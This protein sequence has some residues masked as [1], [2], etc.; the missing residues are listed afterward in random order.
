M[1]KI[2]QDYLELF[3]AF[4]VYKSQ[5]GYNNKLT[6]KQ[7]MSAYRKLVIKVNDIESFSKD[8][9]IPLEHRDILHY[10]SSDPVKSINNN[11]S[12]ISI[13]SIIQKDNLVNI[14]LL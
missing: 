13:N 7:F 2:S 12:N 10:S 11:V 9:C 3:V 6:S 5:G 14:S 4:R 8:N 1:R